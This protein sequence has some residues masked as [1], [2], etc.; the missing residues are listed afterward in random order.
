MRGINLLFDEDYQDV[1]ILEVPEKIAANIESIVRE[2]NAW[3]CIPC[4]GARFL[5]ET[6][7]EKKVLA[8]GTKEFV[9]W[10]NNVKLE[11]F[12]EKEKVKIV[13]QH[14]DYDDS[15]PTACF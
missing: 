8:I 1:D 15:L 9:W 6:A 11:E 4:N 13:K 12:D 2:F 3:L 5:V 7:S 10:L 14:T